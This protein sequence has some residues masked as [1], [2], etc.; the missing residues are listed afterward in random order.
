MK[1]ITLLIFVAL[2]SLCNLMG[3]KLTDPI[4]N[5][6]NVK[7]GKLSNGLTYYIRENKKPENRAEFWLLVNA[8]SMQ[9]NDNQ[10]GLAHF[11]EHMGFNGIKGFPGNK[12]T[13]EL[14]KVGVTFGRDINAYTSFDETVY[15]LTMP[16]NNKKNID[17]AL[18]ILKG[19]ACDY[20]LDNKEIEE[21]RGIIIEEYRLGLGAND[22]MR[23]KWFPVLFNGSRYAERMPIGTL[24][25]LET[26]KPQTLKDF[27]YDW[28]RPDLQAIVIV[29]DINA[30]EIEKMITDKFG[31]IKP[32]KNPREKIE[33]PIEPTKGQVAVV[34]TD[35]EAG[36]NNIMVIRK[37]PHFVMKTV[38]DYKIKMMH[39]LYNLMYD[40]RF[41]E[42]KQNPNTPFIDAG[43]GY[44]SLL[45]NTD[46][47]YS[48]AVAKENQIL[49]SLKA[50][51]QE[52]Y[53]VLKY[54][55]LESELIR[56]KAELLY[57]YEIAAN[58]IDKTESNNFA[59]DYL[60]HFLNH[61]PIPGA[62]R[63]YNY[64]KKYL[65][66]I[67]L[68]EVNALSK[69]WITKDNICVV[70][71]APEKDGVE[72][73][74]EAEILS[75]VRDAS[76]E[77]VEPYIDTYK[78]QEI[79]DVD[80][81]QKGAI[82]SENVIK[83]VD[84][85]EITL[86]NGIKVWLKKTDFKNDEIL[87]N[88]ISKGG[89]CLYD[90][91]DLASALFAPYFVDRAGISDIDFISLQKKMKGKQI[92]LMPGISTFSE[93]INGTSTPKD[94]EFF[95]QY[96]HAF[97]TTPRYDQTV[98]ELVTKEWK[99]QLKMVD[100]MPMYRALKNVV[101]IATQNDYYSTAP[102]VQLTYSEDFINS[103]NYDRAFAIY[104]ERFAN[105]A[106][107]LFTF[108]GNF[109]EKLIREYLELY[110][111][112]LQTSDNKDNVNPK[113]VKGF[114]KEQINENIY[115][116]TEEQSFVGI[117]FQREFPWT[118]ENKTLLSALK[119][120]L[121]IE[122]IAEIREKMSG[123]YSPT[124]ILNWNQLPK[125]EYFM[126]VFF[127]C[128]PN[129]TDNLSNAV[130]KILKEMQ[131]NGPSEETMTKVKQQLIKRQETSFKKN[132]F[133]SNI[134]SNMWMQGDD[135]TTILS[136]E[137]RVNELTSKDI[138]DFLQK[139]FDAEQYVRVNLYPEK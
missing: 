109:D 117:V 99:E 119:D 94:L 110:L 114:P 26:F 122:L 41:E 132:D 128:A 69:K 134:L 78:E 31:K 120:A 56:A 19:W 38:G 98:Y 76:L 55:F 52:D 91:K 21:E 13:D 71:M 39:E 65:D 107:F 93:I 3:Q 64:A 23:K 101:K 27:Y 130:F 2:L 20:L 127:G 40:G 103:A 83:E 24:E 90:E 105:P 82:V 124:L 66:E 135:L 16:T 22:R 48:Q 104:K 139:Y 85:T 15:T 7:V 37:F 118:V 10:V 129:N 77:N 46:I 25:L 87:F 5:D 136:F 89:A 60:N 45:G 1:K 29:G 108:V 58:E 4:N 113:V 9:E 32:K 131:K 53:R 47:Y 36:M 133:W 80:N 14:A 44:G 33:Y 75:M 74:A 84:V 73:P 115:V 97:Y 111:G 67:M 49:P 54:G 123:V 106:D 68:E 28:Y 125:S 81:L 18:N 57:K 102:I 6:P 61:D 8:G 121:D 63:V 50:V 137:E 72:V 30:A 126:M 12:L 11:T 43:T 70:V 79:V 34:C 51:L 138:I 42:L 86:S 96:L 116:G 17:M 92:G 35:K 62:K 88:A 59:Q 100:A 95:F 112:S